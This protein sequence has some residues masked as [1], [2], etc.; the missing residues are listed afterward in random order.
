MTYKGSETA[1]PPRPAKKRHIF[2]AAVLALQAFFIIWLA[3]GAKIGA[4]LVAVIWVAADGLAAGLWV[5]ARLAR[6]W[7]E[8]L[9]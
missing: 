2:A 9:G 4:I 8:D 7:R 3:V 5:V 6:E 1:G